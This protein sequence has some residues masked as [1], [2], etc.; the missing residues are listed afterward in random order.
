MAMKV[1]LLDEQEF[2]D[3]RILHDLPGQHIDQANN[4]A[5]YFANSQFYDASSL[6]QAVFSSHQADPAKFETLHNRRD[7]ERAVQNIKHGLQFMVA[8]EPQGEGQP[9]LLQRQHKVPNAE[10]EVETHVEG[11]YYNQ[12]FYIRQAPSVLDVVR[13]R[14]VRQVTSNTRGQD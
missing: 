5:W 1:P 2:I 14:M 9:W 4:F 13:A 6:N 10:D 7:F 3:P 11:N 12:G 8:G